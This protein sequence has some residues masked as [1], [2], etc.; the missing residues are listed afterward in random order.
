MTRHRTFYSNL[1][2]TIDRYLSLKETLGRRYTTERAVLA[3]LDRFVAAQGRDAE[4]T[5][6]T[7][8]AWAA[9]T[10]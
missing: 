6:E 8:S 10:T 7:F 1:A 3:D 5:A 2:P 9:T 4:L